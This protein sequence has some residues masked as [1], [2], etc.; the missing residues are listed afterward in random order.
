MDKKEIIESAKQIGTY[1]TS[2][3]PHEDCCTL[4]VPKHPATKASESAVESQELSL[5]KDKMIE[6]AVR[7]T[8]I[9]NI[10]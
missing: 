4:F 7:S 1:E 3:L 5:I 2:I 10:R 6:R 8:E 9:K